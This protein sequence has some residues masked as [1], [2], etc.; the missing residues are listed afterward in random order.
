[1]TAP[2]VRRRIRLVALLMAAVVAGSVPVLST[3]GLA[4]CPVL[5]PLG[6]RFGCSYL[7]MFAVNLL[8]LN[9]LFLHRLTRALATGGPVDPELVKSAPRR[10]AIAYLIAYALTVVELL[11]YLAWKD[12]PLTS[13]GPE[14]L[15]IM[16]LL[17]AILQYYGTAW[18]ILPTA[19]T[20][21]PTAPISSNTRWTRGALRVA[22]PAMITAAVGAHFVVRS[23]DLESM[24]GPAMTGHGGSFDMVQLLAFLLVWQLAVMAFYAA[25]E[26]DFAR[27]A[28]KHLDAVGREDFAWRSAELSWGY[29]PGLF[30]AM[31]QLSQGLLERS[32]LLRGFSAFV[33]QRVA[34]EVLQED[35]KFDGKRAEVT[36]L[37]ADLRGFTTLAEKLRPEEVVKLLNLFFYAMIE[38]LGRTGVTV[39]KFIGD[40]LLAYVEPGE[41][42]QPAEEC[43]RAVEAAQAMLRRLETVNGELA[44]L[45]LPRL[46]LGIGIARGPLVVG[47][48]GSLERMQHTVIG[49]TVNL[50][51][52]I[53]GLSKELAADLVIEHHVWGELPTDLQSLFN[54]RG[55]HPV[56]GRSEPVRLYAW[57]G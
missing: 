29:W 57:K 1:M 51:S 47:K 2:N 25:A 31:N 16:A 11:A 21:G 52:R 37:M 17:L 20:N 42:A 53:E 24:I 35:L 19:A 55:D 56:R 41:L 50:A 6:F 14:V 9:T 27:R 43:T 39:D 8:V 33:S 32:R 22:V 36:V 12:L 10:S 34:E 49:D 40:G 38:E 45:G 13:R 26:V 48:I 28:A 30:R 15:A 7:V 4:V 5:L 44:A 54:D 3:Y 18:A 23:A 46:K